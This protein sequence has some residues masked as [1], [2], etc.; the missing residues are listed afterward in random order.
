[1]FSSVS[2]SAADVARPLPGDG[3][4]PDPDVVMDRAFDLPAP[5]DGVWPWFLQLGK[6]R[7]GWYL[8]RRVERFV[9]PSRR[10]LRRL[11][12]VLVDELHVGHVIPDWG[13]SHATFEVALLE[14]PHALVHT[15]QRGRT[16]GS[17]AIVLTPYD[18]SPGRTHVQL[19]LRLS[20]VARPWL[21]HSLGEALD[22]ATVAGLA[23]GLRERL[24]P[25]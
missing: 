13:G 1:V 2:A 16:A 5:P 7:A 15:T 10:G 20:P 12:P 22:A 14:P 18:G 17:W 25:T 11:D 19:R 6:K 3:L 4:V 23:A 8:P 21:A 9:P 24:A